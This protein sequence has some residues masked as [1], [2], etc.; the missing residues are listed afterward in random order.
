ML[1]CVSCGPWRSHL[2]TA[3]LN[4]LAQIL[5]SGDWPTGQKGLCCTS[6][7]SRVDRLPFW[8]LFLFVH[9]CLSFS[10]VF[11]ILC[12]HIFIVF[13]CHSVHLSPVTFLVQ[14]CSGAGLERSLCL[15]SHIW[16]QEGLAKA[17]PSSALLPLRVFSPVGALQSDCRPR[18]SRA[19]V[20]KDGRWELQLLGPGPRNEHRCLDSRGRDIEPTFPGRSVKEVVA[21][22]N[23]PGASLSSSKTEDNILQLF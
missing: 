1:R 4:R 9:A 20:S 13:L 3:P 15:C 8:L 17:G 21:V 10:C 23:P 19:I 5:S 7:L 2:S 22:C 6:R 12:S 16:Y 14:V 18:P 11:R